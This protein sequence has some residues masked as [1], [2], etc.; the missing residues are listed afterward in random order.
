[1]AID[2]KATEHELADH[3]AQLEA[4]LARQLPAEMLQ[5]FQSAIQTLV[6]DGITAHAV[7]VGQKAPDFSLPDQI[8]DIVSLDSVLQRG[9]AVVVFY[10]GEWCPYCDLTLRAY[11]RMLPAITALGAFLIAIS[12]QTPDSTLTTVEKKEL[13]FS[14]LSDVGN[15]VA[16]KYG[17]VFVTPETARHPGI[18][19]ANGD[20][21]WEL[22]MPATFIVAQ[23]GTIRLA[24]VDADWTHRLE[25]A[26]LLKSLEGVATNCLKE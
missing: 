2:Q 24:S 4:N 1:V 22:P 12:P 14:V 20:E 5:G 25:P 18:S 21:S 15:L 23:D 13:T 16:R 6:N 9:P 11:Q 26:E 19:A 10:R 17:L 3:I 7:T 8:G